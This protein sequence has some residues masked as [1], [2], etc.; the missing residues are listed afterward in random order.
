MLKEKA[1]LFLALLNESYKLEAR[2]SLQSI[3]IASS[4]HMKPEDR[5]KLIN[6]LEM[7]SSDIMSKLK[8]NNDYSGL[9]SLKESFKS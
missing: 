7:A 2:E 5:S 6:S 4:P 9:H 1:H 8:E 3:S